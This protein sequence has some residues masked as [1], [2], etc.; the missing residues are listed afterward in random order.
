MSLI[1]KILGNKPQPAPSPGPPSPAPA[2]VPPAAPPREPDRAEQ[3]AAEEARLMEAIAQCDETAIAE[4]ALHGGT[5]KI[6]Q[7][8]AEAITD[9]ER[10]RELI[11]AARGSKDNAVYRILT[12]KRDALLQSE[13]AAAQRQADLDAIAAVIA[14]HARLPYDPL[15]AAT[16]T[17]HERRWR[18]LEAQAPEALKAAVSRDLAAA[19]QVVETHR[20]ELEAAARRRE[21]AEASAARERE[22]LQ[23]AAAERAAAAS[24]EAARRDAERGAQEA[25][26]QAEA[27]AAR[28]A[29]GLLRQTQA[30]LER[31][32]SARA[33][34][35]R[36]SLAR[37]LAETPASA[38]PAWFQRQLERA[39]DALAKLK[40]WHAF[41]AGPKRAELI[42]RMRSLIGAEI[43]P[44]QLALHIR[45]LQQE[46]RTLHRG[47]GEDDGEESARFRALA[48]QAYEPCKLH[49]AA[50]AAQR[51]EN[52]EK[53]EAILA[54]LARCA[55]E[56]AGE[57]ADWR[58]VA[59]TLAR[60]RREW[61]LYAPVDQEIAAT[62]QARFK[63]AVDELGGRL[64]AEYARNVE[65]KR[66]LIARAE[67]LLGLGDVR[68]AIDAAKAL[69]RSWKTIGIVPRDQDGA[70]WEE[71]RRH[72]NAVFERSAQEAAAYSAAL[73]ANTERAVT[74]IS[75]LGRIATLR[76][77]ALREAM[78]GL[79][80]MQEEF[81]GLDLP[82]QQARDLRQ[83]FQRAVTR[84]SEAVLQDRTRAAERAWSALFATAGAI[85]N[86]AWAQARGEPDDRL[87]A[88]RAAATTAVANLGVAPKFARTTLEKRW[89]TVAA[90]EPPSD[91]AANESA[92]RLLCIRAELATDRAT[93]PEDE[94][95]RREYRLRRLVE[96][97][98]LGADAA[99]E[100][101]ND[102]ALEWLV[103]GPV[104]PEV[105]AALRARF[106]QCRTPTPHTR[107]TFPAGQA[108]G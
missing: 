75:E 88:L 20:A 45:K 76:D 96:S 3:L 32:G 44:E 48:N 25:R 105:E 55:A 94:E 61:R 50:Q 81:D 35:L 77:D 30:A 86:Y 80:A 29:V 91:P 97:R 103:V 106:E 47:A 18:A 56:Q 78:K 102:L 36:D 26:A 107:A 59:Q 9:P 22:M 79:E 40:D 24:A 31:G 98:T 73:A 2:A 68:E 57:S 51:A 66:R 74:L 14:R 100:E 69:Q 95:R 60:A 27:E 4:F 38:L 15:Y 19:R 84:C 65:A 83:R 52:R 37:K 89:A 5:T 62:L 108:A 54:E 34:R 53:R 90:G 13:R 7:R 46:W 1:S 99:P 104:A 82:R 42:E 6:R 11:R 58:L 101:L 17:E 21:E 41:T 49:F 39:D 33:V 87:E 10:I 93:P 64:D 67:A 72:C 8:A 28:E 63:T 16:V 70:L 43:A 23:Q 85:R 92:L 71:F 12:S